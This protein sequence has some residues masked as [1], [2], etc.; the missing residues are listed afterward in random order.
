MIEGC[1]HAGEKKIRFIPCYIRVVPQPIIPEGEHRG[2]TAYHQLQ[3][4][5]AK[6]PGYLR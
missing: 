4:H 6:N 3:T 1:S 2:S 5:I